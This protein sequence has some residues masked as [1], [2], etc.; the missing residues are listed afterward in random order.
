[1]TELN[2][3]IYTSKQKVLLTMFFPL[4]Q[5]RSAAGWHRIFLQHGWNF[6]FDRVADSLARC[7]RLLFDFIMEK[8]RNQIIRLVWYVYFIV[9]ERTMYN[10]Y[11]WNWLHVLHVE[12]VIVCKKIF[13]IFF[14]SMF[15][16]EKYE[17]ILNR[18]NQYFYNLLL[19]WIF[20]L[21]RYVVAM[22]VE[23][24]NNL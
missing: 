2:T 20:K 10:A 5:R 4:L 17:L 12:R 14:K 7:H 15:F 18:W 3:P 21:E 19:G 1:M 23:I 8:K 22:Y 11:V 24:K 9:A 13:F 6:C 16:Y